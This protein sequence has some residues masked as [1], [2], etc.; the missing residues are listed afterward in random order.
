MKRIFS[1]KWLLA[2]IL[3]LAAMAVMVRLGIWQLDRLDSRRAFNTRVMSAMSQP[4]LALQGN[5]LQEPLQD[6]EY[7]SAIVTGEYDH[8]QQI[9]LR[10]QYYNNQWGVH[11]VTPLKI[12]GSDQAV[13]VDRGWIPAADFESG[14]WSKYDEP[15][16]VTVQG[17]IRASRSQAD[18]GSRSDPTPMP[19]GEPLRAWNFVNI[20]AIQ[21]QMTLVLLP[22]YIQQSP[23][24]AAMTPIR[25]EVELDL[26]EGPHMGYALQWFTFAAILGIGYLVYIRRHDQR[27]KPIQADPQ[28]LENNQ[29]D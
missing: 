28:T 18:F 11:L 3:V 8:S 13:L 20:P 26:S 21:Q 27:P 10:N 24:S 23:T 9:A 14:D 1:K 29:I 6:M 19:G 5:G 25:T 7:R 16:T 15:G 22:A 2:T 17:M 12:S 4:E